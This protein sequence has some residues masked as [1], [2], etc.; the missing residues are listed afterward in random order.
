MPW[1]IGHF[2]QMIFI[3]HGMSFCKFVTTED[4]SGCNNFHHFQVEQMFSLL[5]KLFETKQRQDRR[6]ASKANSGFRGFFLFFF[7][8][9][10][11]SLE[12]K[13]QNHRWSNGLQKISI[14]VLA[15]K[16]RG[17]FEDTW[18]ADPEN[19]LNRLTDNLY[20][21]DKGPPK[22]ARFVFLHFFLI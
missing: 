12:I 18:G 7:S 3:N 14:E 21:R 8:G 9:D 20:M 1:S 10:V 19:M 4:S 16:N 6:S 22:S 17:T 2:N 13:K 15:S 11:E 5:M